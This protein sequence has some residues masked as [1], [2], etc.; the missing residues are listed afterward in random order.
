[1][2]QHESAAG[3]SSPEF[4]EAVERDPAI[5]TGL[6]TSGALPDATDFLSSVLQETSGDEA[7]RSAPLSAFLAEESPAKAIE[8]WLGRLLSAERDDANA[9]AI[10]LNRDVAVIDGLLN[11]QLNEI[12]HHPKF[13]KLESSW[14]GI[15]YLH[16]VLVREYDPAGPDV[17]IKILDASWADLA[18]DFESA[19]SIEQSSLFYKVYEQ[20]F[21]QAG[22]EPF[23]LLIG[24]YQIQPPGTATHQQDDYSI[25]TSIASVAASAFS[26]F[27]TNASPAQFQ[28]PE[29]GELEELQDLTDAFKGPGAVRWQS[30]CQ[31]EDSRF[32]GLAMPHILMRVP[33]EDRPDATLARKQQ[34]SGPLDNRLNEFCFRED[35]RGPDTSKYLWGGAAFAFAGVVMRSFC[36]T[37]WL[38]DIRG[39]DRNDDGGG[40]VSDLP[41][42]YNA[43]DTNGVSPKISTDVI[44]TDQTEKEL[45]DLGFIPL[46]SCYDTG[47][48]AFYSARS[49][50]KPAKYDDD[51][52]NM[53][54]HVSTMLY[55][56]LCASRFAHYL[57]SIGRDMVGR[58]ADASQ[59][60]RELQNW[61]IQFV[62]DPSAST[63]VKSRY[64]LAAANVSVKPA[65]GRSGVFRSVF[66]LQ[67]H[68][69]I[70]GLSASIRLVTEI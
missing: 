36:R 17:K 28:L 57:K 2:S 30:L 24:D 42:E 66:H 34:R 18:K 27:V 62:T 9:I 32:I 40:L 19:Y 70:E 37:G 14:R 65:P 16:H 15:K 33:Y 60:E 25:L 55:T 43:T 51:L 58:S 11:Q 61:I 31:K 68:Y 5:E 29:F 20:E 4:A 64:P 10:R 46:C 54:A 35:V 41:I 47:F 7:G 50:Q 53:N 13:Q 12:L 63:A 49:I 59:I 3:N 22:G 56:M 23:G 21:G 48:N 6:G 45:T 1:M 39:V 52:A 26:P 38:T 8:I 69:E 44:I 67:P